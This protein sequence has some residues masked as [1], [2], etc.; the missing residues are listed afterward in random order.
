MEQHSSWVSEYGP[1]IASAVAL[2]IAVGNVLWTVWWERRRRPMLSL[3]WD[4]AD[5]FAYMTD[6]GIGAG[7]VGHRLRV[8]VKNERGKQSA[9]DVELLVLALEEH[10]SGRPRAVT[11]GANLIWANRAT[12]AGPVTTVTLPPVVQRYVDVLALN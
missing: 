12:P 5:P 11:G 6:V 1:L 8:K 7:R 10:E 4:P 3:A 9:D 2:L